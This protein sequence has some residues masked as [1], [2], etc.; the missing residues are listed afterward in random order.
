MSKHVINGLA[1][2]VFR[3]SSNAR[4]RSVLVN[5]ALGVKQSFYAHY[6]RALAAQ[7]LDVVTYDYSGVGESR[8][9]G[10]Q[11]AT[12]RDWY[13]RDARAALEFAA[14]EFGDRPVTLVGHSI[15]AQFLH[16]APDSAA[17]GAV[18]ALF[19][20]SSMNNEFAHQRAD[21]LQTRIFFRAIVP[22]ACHLCDAFPAKRLG[23]FE[24]VP[25]GVMLEWLSWMRDGAPFEPI[26]GAAPAAVASL[27]FADDEYGRESAVRDFH[28]RVYG[29]QNVTY[30]RP[31]LR[32]VGHHGFFKP[33]HEALWR[34]T[35]PRVAP[36]DDAP[37]WT[38]DWEGRAPPP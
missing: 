32:G 30:L 16:L 18:D 14:S 27:S 26:A 36:G 28:D 4:S 10:W 3:A 12:L 37:A 17:R 29:D 1:L 20:V 15:G 31:D 33:Q 7:G 8:A 22:A 13:E 34:D 21:S 19:T 25:G 5:G 9:A 38:G 24:D 2:R 35:L 6:A 11:G 23:L